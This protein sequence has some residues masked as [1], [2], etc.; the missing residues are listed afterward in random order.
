MR[1]VRTMLVLLALVLVALDGGATALGARHRKPICVR[2]RCR[3]LAATAQIRVYQARNRPPARE[4]PVL[5][6]FARWLPTGRVTPLGD[7][8]EVTSITQLRL[9]ALSGR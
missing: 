7:G 1:R 2:Y 5:S 9:L 8:V 4:L 3:T 6:S